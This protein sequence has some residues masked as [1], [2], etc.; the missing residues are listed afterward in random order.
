MEREGDAS[1]FLAPLRI[2]VS[3]E[4]KNNKCVR[5]AAKIEYGVCMSVNKTWGCD[6]LAAISASRGYGI[7]S[8]CSLTMYESGD[9]GVAFSLNAPTGCEARNADGRLD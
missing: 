6:E 8:N 5:A 4:Q 3:V 1:E 7:T 9:V 2:R